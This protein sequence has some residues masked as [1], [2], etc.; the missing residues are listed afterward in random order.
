[1]EKSQVQGPPISIEFAAGPNDQNQQIDRKFG[2]KPRKDGVILNVRGWSCT[3]AGGTY[4]T[5]TTRV[6]DVMLVN[7]Q[8]PA[9]IIQ[10][11]VTSSGGGTW[12][13]TFPKPPA[14]N[15]RVKAI[16]NT[17]DIGWSLAFDCPDP[18]SS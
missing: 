13:G 1:M 4:S 18:G 14:G 7:T 12:S 3:S 10:G 11:T 5:P 6:V 17:G 9:Q 2:F 15:Y 8:A 16:G